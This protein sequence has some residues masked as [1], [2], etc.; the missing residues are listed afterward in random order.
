ML[1]A[2][3]FFKAPLFLVT[4]TV[5]HATG[6]RDVRRLSG[7]WTPCAAARSPPPRRP[8]RWSACRRC[9]ASSARRPGSRRSSPR[10]TW[11]APRHAR[12]GRRI[13]VHRPTAPGSSGAPSPASPACLTPRCTA[14]ADPDLAG[15]AVARSPGSRWPASRTRWSTPTPELR[16]RLPGHVPGGGRLPP[17]ALARRRAAAAG[18]R[19]RTRARPSAAPRRGRVGRLAGLVPRALSAQRGYEL[20]VGGT[21]RVATVVTGRLQAG[22][23]PTY[24]AVILLTVVALPGTAVLI[25]GLWPDQPVYHALLQLPLAVLTTLAALAL[26]RVRRRFTAVLLVGV[27]GY[28][29][30]GCSSS[31]APRTSRWPSSSSRLSLVAFVFVLRRMPARFTREPVQKRVQVPKAVIAA[32]AGG[33]VAATAVVLSGARQVPPTTSAE[34]IRLAP[35]VPGR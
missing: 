21:E 35:R 30:G 5:D 17:R 25:G 16:R 12:A 19:R 10:T 4:G 34:F 27:V 11:R 18:V 1:L 31:T 26:V 6:T 24:L 2:H 28:G 33:M 23:V 9:S 22:S 8:R 13:G 15:R 32:V 29:V 14:G 7:M 3:G 20:A